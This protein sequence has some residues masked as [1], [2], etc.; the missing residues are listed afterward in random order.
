M[1]ICTFAARELGRM[2]RP[3]TPAGAITAMS[4]FSPSDE[5]LSMV[6]V[7]NSGLGAGRD[8]LGGR[9]SAT[10]RADADR[11]A[12]AGC[13]VRCACAR[14]SCSFTCSVC[15][16]RRR[17]FVLAVHVA[18]RDVAVHSPRTPSNA[19]I[20]QRCN[21]E[22]DAEGHHLEERNAAR[23]RHLRRDQDQVEDAAPDRPARGRLESP[24]MAMSVIGPAEAGPH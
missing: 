13:R 8:D 4:G 15:S 22:N 17:C 12:A 23:G 11:G 21:S 1:S 7:R 24:T 14:S 16:S 10:R 18:Q 6:I 9:S 2:T 3:T 19:V 20:V 5:P